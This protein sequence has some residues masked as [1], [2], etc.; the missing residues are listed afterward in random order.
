MGIMFL[1]VFGSSYRNWDPIVPASAG[2]DAKTVLVCEPLCFIQVHPYWFTYWHLDFLA[3]AIAFPL[4]LIHPSKLRNIFTTRAIFGGAAFFVMFGKSESLTG[5]YSLNYFR[6]FVVWCT[7]LG[8]RDPKG[9]Q[10]FSILQANPISG[11]DLGWAIM[12]GINSIMG[13]TAPMITNQSDVSRYARTPKQAG[14]PQ[15]FAI[16][17]TKTIMAFMSIVATS[18][19]QSRYGGIPLW[20]IWDQLHLLLDENWDAKTRVG[21]CVFQL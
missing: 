14:W 11:P 1:C 12:S 9:F 18:S 7:T 3:W 8:Q 15:G 21:W 6:C 19:L 17:T 10:G 20:N 2:A 13:T 4:T 16:F 5:I